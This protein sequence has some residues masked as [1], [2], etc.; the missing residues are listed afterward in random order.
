MEV[1]LR[2]DVEKLGLRGDV[3]SVADG[4]ARNFLIPRRLAER[5]TAGKVAELR[6]REE[7][8]ERQQARSVEEAQQVADKLAAAELRFDVAA[9]PTGRL[10]GSV[11]PTAIADAIWETQKV[12]VDRRKIHLAEPIK[13]IGR[14]EVP[15]ELFTDVVVDV[16]AVV[17]PEGG[18]LPTDEEL[19]AME[20]EERAEAEAA[21]A[22]AAPEQIE[23][24]EEELA[25][26]EASG[27]GEP[28]AEELE[29]PEDALDRAVDTA[30][31]AEGEDVSDRPQA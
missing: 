10:F 27:P 26:E 7:L 6:K 25:E 14:H 30:V 11:T 22:E 19:A 17:V 4:Y 1:I 15:I 3:V 18:E 24:L 2:E 16:R 28:P 5:A 12:R 31:E 8:R 29:V 23:G 21:A 9:G 13:R 20:A